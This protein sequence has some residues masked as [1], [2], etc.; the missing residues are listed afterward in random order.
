MAAVDR[1]QTTPYSYQTLANAVFG[2]RLAAGVDFAI[3][4]HCF[5]ALVAYQIIIGDLVPA[6]LEEWFNTSSFFFSRVGVALFLNLCVIFP[7]SLLRRMSFLQHTSL[8]AIGCMLYLTGMVVIHAITHGFDDAER[9]NVNEVDLSRG[10]Q[11]TY[12]N[13]SPRI[14]VAL[15]IIGFA[16]S[17]HVQI[18]KIYEELRAR[19]TRRQRAVTASAI[20][21]CLVVY[22][23]VG[24]FGYITFGV[25]VDGNVFNNFTDEDDV[26]VGVAKLGL[27]LTL[28][29]ST[30]LFIHP[31][32]EN[33]VHL[34]YLLT[35]PHAA[36][37]PALAAKHAPVIELLHWIPHTAITFSILAIAGILGVLVPNVEFVLSLAG[38]TVVSVLVFMLPSTFYLLSKTD[39]DS[40]LLKWI[41]FAMIGWGFMLLIVGTTVVFAFND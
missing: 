14:F 37:D 12:F 40:P 34:H 7:L 13:L 32:R 31:M 22:A 10:R 27:A 23:T 2:R 39:R 1:V 16:F 28:M 15:P 8:V 19:S 18:P 29:F 3:L 36:A 4:L 41:A 26:W 21:V 20:F 25:A 38:A 17:S 33:A 11:L 35:S 9:G 24:I 6:V 5:S 30:P